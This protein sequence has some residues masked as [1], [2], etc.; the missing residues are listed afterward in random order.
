M[1][2]KM[3]RP[4][5]EINWEQFDKLCGLQCTLLEIAS[6]FDCSDDTIENRV[7]EVH[8]ITFSEYFA[9]KRGKGKIALRRKQY[10]AA[11]AG[12][13]TLLIWLGKQYLGQSDKQENTNIE[14]V[15]VNEIDLDKDDLQL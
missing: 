14:G 4:R 1:A 9:K 11:I 10:E 2:K 5:I 8:G 12:N 7:K 6:Y 3:G 13:T 15:K